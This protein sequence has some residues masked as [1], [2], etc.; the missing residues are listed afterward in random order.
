MRHAARPRGSSLG[1]LH[2]SGSPL[3]SRGKRGGGVA[4]ET[5]LLRLMGKQPSL[6]KKPRFRRCRI[7]EKEERFYVANIF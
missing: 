4:P 7:E 3:T 5:A 6:G 1:E 2:L